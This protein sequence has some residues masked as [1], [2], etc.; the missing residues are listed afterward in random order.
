[1]RVGW[2]LTFSKPVVDYLYRMK[3]TDKSPEIDKLLQIV[4]GGGCPR[5]QAIHEGFCMMCKGPAI[6]FKDDLSRR[7]FAISGLCQKCQDSIFE[8]PSDR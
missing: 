7:E 1:M 4:A 3:P 8:T 2:V 6:E 5:R